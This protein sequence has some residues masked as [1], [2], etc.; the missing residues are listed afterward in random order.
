MCFVYKVDWL[1]IEVLR[2]IFQQSAG[3]AKFITSSAIMERKG[4]RA[5]SRIIVTVDAGLTLHFK[6]FR[7]NN[8]SI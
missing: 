3:T 8:F 7:N 1:T 4:E 2:N 6:F 5:A